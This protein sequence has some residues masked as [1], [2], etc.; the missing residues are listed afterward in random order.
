MPLTTAQYQPLNVDDD[1]TTGSSTL[2]WS[3][4]RRSFVQPVIDASNTVVQKCLSFVRT[5][6]GLLLVAA[7]QGFFA[8]MNVAVKKLNSLDPPV[9][10]LEVCTEV[11]LQVVERVCFWCH[12]LS[13]SS[14][15]PCEW[16]ILSL[17]GT[18]ASSWTM[19]I[20]NNPHMLPCL[21]VRLLPI[22]GRFQKLRIL[23]QPLEKSTRSISWSKR[24]TAL[25]RHSRVFGV[26]VVLSA[27]E[28]YTI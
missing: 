15:L 14:L 11:S 2:D 20:G 17:D 7:S 13:P 10:A 5:N 9:P 3:K 23:L 18:D 27:Y 1:L 22:S 24:C 6:A 21:S 28:Q 25:T 26:R 19:C 4:P 16:Y 8:L 12:F